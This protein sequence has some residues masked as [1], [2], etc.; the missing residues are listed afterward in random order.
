MK[1]YGGGEVQIIRYGVM[2]ADAAIQSKE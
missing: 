2:R 1:S